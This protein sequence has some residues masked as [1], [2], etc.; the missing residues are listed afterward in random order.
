M[1]KDLLTV[2][3]MKNFKYWGK[4]PQNNKKYEW[5]VHVQEKMQFY[6]LSESRVL[7]VLHSPKRTE[8]G[9]APNTVAMMQPS[10]SSKNPYEIWVMYQEIGSLKGT[11]NQKKKRIITAWRYPG[12]SP[13][14]NPIPEDVLRE[15]RNFLP[16]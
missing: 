1:N 16:D 3:K 4:K 14:R 5:T 8:W 2:S 15:I 9:I 10:I 7:R 6:N 11:L 12:K 13:V